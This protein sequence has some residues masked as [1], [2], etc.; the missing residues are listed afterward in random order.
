[1]LLM[2]KT[3]EKFGFCTAKTLE[4]MGGISPATLKRYIADARFYGCEIVSIKQVGVPSYELRNPGDVIE[5]VEAWIKMENRKGQEN[6][7]K[8]FATYNVRA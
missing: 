2:V 3:L 8:A 6:G 4:S 5:G 7:L 1:M